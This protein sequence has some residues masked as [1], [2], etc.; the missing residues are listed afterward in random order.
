MTALHYQS[1]KGIVDTTNKK[2]GKSLSITSGQKTSTLKY[3][4][5]KK[6]VQKV[7]PSEF[8]AVKPGVE[9]PKVK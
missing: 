6:P 4:P 9:V 3:E 2:T 7:V 1:K 8:S 5:E